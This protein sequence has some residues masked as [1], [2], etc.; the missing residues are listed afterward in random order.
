MAKQWV[1]VLTISRQYGGPEE[2]GWWYDWY[3]V[4]WEGRYKR[5][6]AKKF[7]KQAQAIAQ[8][9]RPRRNRFSVIGG[10]DWEARMG[11]YRVLP[12]THRPHY[13]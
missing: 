7:F 8:E 13:C 3:T 2:G 1:Q 10:D 6:V 11:K 4:E 12:T 5:R 9:N